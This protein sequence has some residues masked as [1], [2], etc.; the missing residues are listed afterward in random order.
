MKGHRTVPPTESAQLLLA[1]LRAVGC[2]SATTAR[3]ELL[4]ALARCSKKHRASG[5]S[6]VDQA[7]GNLAAGGHL[8]WAVSAAYWA[9]LRKEQRLPPGLVFTPPALAEQ[10]ADRLRKGL[11]VIDLGAGTGMLSLTA[12]ARGFNV[13]AV[14]QDRELVLILGALAEILGVED[15]VEIVLGDAFS[16]RGAEGSQIMANPPY[17]RH[18]LLPAETK[19]ALSEL[20]RDLGTPLPL[21]AGHYAY[22]MVHAWHATWSNRD[23]LLVPTNWLETHYGAPL[24]GHLRNRGSFDVWIADH[25]SVASAFGDALTTTCIVTTERE[26]TGNGTKVT[27]GTFQSLNLS[28]LRTVATEKAGAALAEMWGRRVGSRDGRSEGRPLIVGDVFHVR[29]GVA[30]GAN[31]FFVLSEQGARGLNIPEHEFVPIVRTLSPAPGRDRT[32]LLWVASADPSSPSAARIHEGERLQIDKRYLCRSRNPWWRIKIPD[33]PQYL[34]SYMGHCEPHVQQNNDGLINL[35]NIH[36]LYL[37]DGVSSGLARRT[38]EWLATDSGRAALLWQA[39]HYQK[40]LWKL[41]P[42]DVE[43]VELPAVLVEDPLDHGAGIPIGGRRT[44]AK[45]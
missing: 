18:H 11:R 41:E 22:F 29:R 1:S 31:S 20:A 44:R 4:A 15:R 12:A 9:L 36:G 42:G 16:Y 2:S 45:A 23:V 40:G 34:L 19:R 33:P 30:T 38:V 35:N 13:T 8:A 26:S 37:V 28:P 6:P 24:R 5:R 27:P 14:E 3:H 25:R 39:R 21:T 10:V 32:G 17:T 43:Q 7:I